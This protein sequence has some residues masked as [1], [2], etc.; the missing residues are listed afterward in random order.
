MRT[1]LLTV[2]AGLVLLGSIASAQ[3]VVNHP[4]GEQIPGPSCQAVPQWYSGRARLCTPGERAD[5]LAD[6]R[7]WRNERRIRIGF[8][9]SEYARPAL[10]WTHSSFIQP[11]MMV[12]DRFFYDP[13]KREYTVDKY[14][15]DLK[16]RYGGIDSVLIWHT[17]PNIGIDDRNQYDM[18]QDLPGGIPGIRRM[19]SDFHEHG[20]RV[21]FPVMVW[22][23]G[24]RP[25]AVPDW[26]A[27]SRELVEV[28]ADGINGDTL[29]GMPR[30]FREASDAL[31]HPLA[32]EPEGGLGADE[33]INY[34]NMTWGYWK[35]SFIPSVSRYKW[36]E[37]RHMVNICNRWAHN[38]LDDLQE[39]FFN[40]VGFESWE[41][42]WGIWNQLTPRDAEA[43]RRV[44]AIE[45]AYSE[46]LVSDGWEPHVPVQ[47]YGIFASK[48]P[49]KDRT[50]WT[51][52]NRNS[53]DVTGTQMSVPVIAGQHFYDVWH[54]VELVPDMDHGMARLSFPME[55]NGYGAVL[56]TTA[57]DAKDKTLLATMKRLSAKP[58]NSFSDA[59]TTLSQKLVEIA[60]AQPAQGAPEGMVLVP[61][62]NFDFRV[63]GIEIEGM[64]DEGVDVQYPW[65]P[66]A[67][68]YHNHEMHIASF[69]I[70]KY[71]VTNAEFKKFLDA[72]QYHPADDHNFLRDWKNGNYPDGWGK[73]PVTWVSL[74]D[75]RA[76]AKW[77]GKRLPHEW[78]WQYAAQ[79]NDGRK[80]P[81]GNLDWQ[82]PGACSS[83]CKSNDFAP[84]PDKGR[85]MQPAA[86]VDAHPDGASPFGVMD[87][88]GNVWQ[89]TDEYVDTHT[90]AAILR[91]GSHY[92]PQGARW[93]F[94]QAYELSEHGKYL[95][96]APSLDRSGAIGFRCV[97]DVK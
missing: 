17:Y 76:Y 96:M 81:W 8:N 60:P 24:T 53:Y 88:V 49:G 39:A 14:L 63:N 92:Q 38:H 22:D 37:T 94:P 56:E 67:R 9:P 93:Y 82:N 3:D 61:A 34:N 77:A 13:V 72:T 11:Q 43:V 50:L 25:E 21:L 68:R 74:E 55:A 59:W 40:G 52:V 91:G 4:E 89:W 10:R 45:R 35:Y 46:L 12:H 29:D 86:D 70:D 64:D 71:P 58:L 5:W 48:W 73:K 69:W 36:L 62:N 44:A 33:M 90:R 18:F 42:I 30:A 6:V 79:G 31:N 97:K 7:H 57:L 84:M 78:E 19:V 26:T 32:L 41:N 28:G 1:R 51:I 66:S 23:Q 54:G 27:I 83:I 80:Y 65:E 87:M 75:A 47:N 15:N 2:L 95:L 16:A 85:V 20:V